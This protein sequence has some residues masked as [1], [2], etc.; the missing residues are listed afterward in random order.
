MSS[1][2]LVPF[3]IVLSFK[4]QQKIRYKQ[5]MISHVLCSHPGTCV[6]LR[7]LRVKSFTCNS[8]RLACIRKSKTS[9]KMKQSSLAFGQR[10]SCTTV[11]ECEGHTDL[12]Q[13]RTCKFCFT[14]ASLKKRCGSTPNV[15]TGN[16]LGRWGTREQMLQRLLKNAQ[17]KQQRRL[18]I[19]EVKQQIAFSGGTGKS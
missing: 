3:T 12:R 5:V 1:G 14:I 2:S 19:E 16:M 7:V 6:Y 11:R 13:I 10:K 17:K 15:I 18:Q 8:Q 9:G 4:K